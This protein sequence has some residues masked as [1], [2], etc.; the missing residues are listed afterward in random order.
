MCSASPSS[1]PAEMSRNLLTHSLTHIKSSV[2]CEG[3][4]L[5]S[6]NIPGTSNSAKE[7]TFTWTYHGQLNFESYLHNHLLLSVVVT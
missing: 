4:L 5:Q 1:V 3:L 6:E 2:D 7:L